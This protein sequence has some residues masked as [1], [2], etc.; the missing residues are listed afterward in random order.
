MVDKQDIIS[1]IGF[2]GSGKSTVGSLLS[3]RLNFHFVDL[4]KYLEKEEKKSINEIFADEGEDFFRDR[5]SYYLQKVLLKSKNIVLATGG[6]VILRDENRSLL[7]EYSFVIYLKGDFDTLIERLENT[8]EKEKRPLL[9]K[10]RKELYELWKYRSDLYESTAHLIIEVDNKT[11]FQI[12][13][14]IIN[15]YEKL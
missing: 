7:R 9:K 5:E 6:G 10:S 14:E 3:E 12:V 4:D 1:F 2:M 15:I 13:E 11:P 8:Y